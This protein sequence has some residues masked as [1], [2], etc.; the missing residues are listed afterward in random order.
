MA[1]KGDKKNPWGSGG[2][3][4]SGGSSGGSG[5]GNGGW[6]GGDDRSGAG[7]SQSRPYSGGGG[8]MDDMFRQVQERFNG[9]IPGQHKPGI[10]VLLIALVCIWLLTG[11]YR[12]LP[13]EHAVILRFGEWTRTQAHSGLG[14]HMPWP[15]E[16]VNKVNVTFER[17]IEIGFRGGSVPVRGTRDS[18]GAGVSVPSESLMVTGDEN[19]IDINFVVLW[20]IADAGKYLFEIRNPEDTI[21]KVAESAMREVVGRTQIQRALAEARGEIEA[22]TRELM[23]EM[24]D[25]Y[26][27][28]VMINEVQLQAVNPPEQVVDAFDD[29]LRA[30]AD[31]DR[32]RNEAEAYRNRILPEARGEAER[33]LQQAEAYKAEVVNNATGDAERF[34]NIYKAYAEAKDVTAKRMY[35]E[36]MQEIMQRSKKFIIGGEGTGVLPYL[37]LDALKERP[38]G[39]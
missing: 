8:N 5:G 17:R 10:A 32:L 2:G 29:V 19:I 31:K 7:R 34:L 20:R 37:P 25:D 18:G 16:T 35:L 1:N 12:V 15:I 21:K 27:S 30:R 36:T 9:F 14:Y 3:K 38:P 26:E 11:F 28:G 24:M 39:R 23:Q 13:E 4:K 6:N 33:I 22:F